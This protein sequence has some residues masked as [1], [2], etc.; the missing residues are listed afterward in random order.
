MGFMDSYK[1]LEKLCGEVMGDDRCVAAYIDEMYNTP[2]GASLV[3]GWEDDLRKL[4]HYKRVRNRISHDPDCTE[5]NMC[6]TTDIQW[7]ENFHDRI[8]KQTDPLALYRKATQRKKAA[9][10]KNA[11]LS[12]NQQ[13]IRKDRDEFDGRAT[14]L[15]FV[16]TILLLFAM[17][18][19]VVWIVGM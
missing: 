7:I 12:R 16:L 18:A 9:A 14:F 5:K 11:S 19:A 15:G 2:R 8:M 6:K 4:K 10:Q 3:R 17:V 1:R 13:T